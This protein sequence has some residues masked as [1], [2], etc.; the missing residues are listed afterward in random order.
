M[1]NF[2]KLAAAGALSLA[3]VSGSAFAATA[4]AAQP[5]K[6]ATKKAPAKKAPAHAAKKVEKKAN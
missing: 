3:I 6:T 4:P 1:R 2:A 5:A